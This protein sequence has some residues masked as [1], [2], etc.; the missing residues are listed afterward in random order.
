MDGPRHDDYSRHGFPSARFAKKVGLPNDVMGRL[1]YM[2]DDHGMTFSQ[3]ADAI[4]AWDG[5]DTIG[6]DSN[7][8]AG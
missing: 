7:H 6:G 3:I 1:A 2:N 4:E 8:Q 5:G